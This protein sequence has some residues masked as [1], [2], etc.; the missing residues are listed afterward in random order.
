[1]PST[2]LPLRVT[3]D[4]KLAQ[5]D[6]FDAVLGVIRIMA[7]TTATSLPHAR[8]FGLFELFHEASRREK[9]D[10]ENLKDAINAA[11]RELGVAEFQVQSVTTGAIDGT[12]RRGFQMTMVDGRGDARFGEIAAG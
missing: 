5:Q 4:G 11:L 3:S 1:M 7:G 2:A 6:S 8:W 10:H 9:Q 12:G